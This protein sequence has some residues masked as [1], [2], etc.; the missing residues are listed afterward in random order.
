MTISDKQLKKSLLL[1]VLVATVSF[2]AQ[3]AW[4]EHAI[5]YVVPYPPG[6]TNDSAARIV[7][8]G[9]EKTLGQPVVVENRPG[10]G[11]TIGAAYVAHAK[12]DGYTL[13]NAS[14]GNI[15]I[16]PQLVTANFD[17]FKDF[18]PL[19]HIGG[20]RSVIAVNPDLPI[21]TIPELIAYAKANPGKL[22][23]GTSGNGTPGNI[24]MEYLKL[25]SGS[26]ILHVPYKGS[27]ASLSDAVAGHIDLVSDPLANGFVKS[28]KLRG[29][30]FFGT[31]KAEDLPG[32]PPITNYYPQWQ[33]SGSFIALAPAQTPA[34]VVE[35]LRASYKSV[36]TDPEVVKA[37]ENIG[38]TPEWKSPQ[39]TQALVQA[40]W[41]I[42][43][44]II[45]Q[46][47]IHAN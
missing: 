29:L 37:L 43:K 11:G 33:F 16:A 13:F 14:I 15:A 19:A 22:T 2:S 8:Q 35:Q 5:T 39:Q 42:S 3:A 6:G 40:T 7:A 34:P 17:S 31:E 47:N 32:V 38:V 27:A 36:L 28:G 46:A 4:P 1:T 41:D 20:S 23:Y 26:D 21:H 44:N 9:L 10:A 25:L 24:S 12:P 30:A 18:T 45:K